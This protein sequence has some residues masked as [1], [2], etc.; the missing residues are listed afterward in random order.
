MTEKSYRYT[1]EMTEAYPPDVRVFISRIVP[2]LVECYNFP[3]EYDKDL[4]LEYLDWGS[5]YALVA[6]NKLLAKK[7]LLV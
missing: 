1:L 2:V 4:E 6:K 5:M 7:V 3:A